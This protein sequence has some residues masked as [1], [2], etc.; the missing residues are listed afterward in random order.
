MDYYGGGTIWVDD[1]TDV[2]RIF[3]G[4][5]SYDKGAWVCHML[6]GVLGEFKFFAGVDAYYNS[7]FKYG[8]ANTE[9][10][11]NVFEAATGE[12]L[13]WFFDEWIYGT[14]YPDYEYS[15]FQE[16]SDTGG[17][18]VYLY[19]DQ[20]QN[21]MPR[22]FHMPVDFFFNQSSGPDDTLTPENRRRSAVVPSESPDFSEPDSLGPLGLDIETG[23]AGVLDDAYR[24]G[25]RRVIRRQ[26]ERSLC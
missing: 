12:E 5:L 16:P 17:Y 14:Y 20:T 21:T 3:N 10:F 7:E 2:W 8:A 24:V 25:R 6:R 9:D 15:Y 26:Q 22:V 13:D 11:K 1:T 19:I 4:S 23:D 18:D